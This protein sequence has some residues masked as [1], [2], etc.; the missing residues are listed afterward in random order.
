MRAWPHAACAGLSAG[1]ASASSRI[2]PERADRPHRPPPTPNHPTTSHKHNPFPLLP[3]ALASPAMRERHW[4]AIM[5]ITGKDLV[6]A[7][8]VFKLQHLL[9]CNLLQH[10][11]AGWQ[12]RQLLACG[13]PPCTPMSCG[14]PDGVV[15]GVCM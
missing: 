2:E 6:L 7:E 11:W 8:D 10:R 9:E 12:D 4:R 5:A 1:A 3:Q 15:V 13:R 14:R